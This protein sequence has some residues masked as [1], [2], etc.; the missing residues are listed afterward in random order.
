[1]S[2]TYAL[3]NII[4]NHK[5]ISPEISDLVDNDGNK[6]CLFL[7]LSYHFYHHHKEIRTAIAN[8]LS[9]LTN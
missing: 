7:C 1:M 6:N 2:I 9:I 5:I 3:K 8:R 4:I